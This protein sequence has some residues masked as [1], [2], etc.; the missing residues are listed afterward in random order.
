MTSMVT[1]SLLFLSITPFSIRA[2]ASSYYPKIYKFLHVFKCKE[3]D[4]SS[5]FL[6]LEAH[7]LLSYWSDFRKLN[8]YHFVITSERTQVC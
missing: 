6:H 5:I 8:I 2:A 7:T 3:I 1:G 4:E